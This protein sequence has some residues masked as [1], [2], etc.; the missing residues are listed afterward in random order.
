M[1]PEMLQEIEVRSNAV[2]RA[3]RIMLRRRTG[4]PD[5]EEWAWSA[6]RITFAMR[7]TC[8]RAARRTEVL[9]RT[10]STGRPLVSCF[11]FSFLSLH[12]DCIVPIRKDIRLSDY[13]TFSYRGGRNKFHATFLWYRR[14]LHVSQSETCKMVSCQPPVSAFF[15]PLPK[16]LSFPRR[17]PKRAAAFAH[18]AHR[19]SPDFMGLCAH[20]LRTYAPTLHGLMRPCSMDLR[21][22]TLWTYASILYGLTCPCSP[23]FTA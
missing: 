3:S 9:Y 21:T 18:G 4:E 1:K 14:P 17:L 5:A 20:A 23:C 11:P 15:S 19:Q 16:T 10:D 12:L 2:S 8:E 7:Q 13:P 6:V 22:H